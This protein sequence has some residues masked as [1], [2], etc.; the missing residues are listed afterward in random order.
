MNK[1]SKPKKSGLGVKPGPDEIKIRDHKRRW[2]IV[3]KMVIKQRII[4][5][6][7]NDEGPQREIFDPPHTFQVEETTDPVNQEPV[8]Q[9][10]G[11][12]SPIYFNKRSLQSNQAGAYQILEEESAEAA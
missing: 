8:Y 9:T 7:R 2:I 4:G 11:T 12:V 6:T 3:R 10:V 5:Y 1:R